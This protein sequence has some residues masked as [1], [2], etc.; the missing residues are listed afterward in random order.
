MINDCDLPATLVSTRLNIPYRRVLKIINNNIS[1]A[2]EAFR[3][4]KP[5]QRFK[6]LPERAREMIRDLIVTSEKP[7][8]ISDIKSMIHKEMRINLSHSMINRYLKSELNV[9]FRK[10]RPVSYL[11]NSHDSKLQR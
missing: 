7:V 1:N 10:L 2:E 3:K 4:Y 9:S 11:Y 8:W 5:R 6:K